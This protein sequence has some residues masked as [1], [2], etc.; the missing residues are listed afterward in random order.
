M[1]FNPEVKIVEFEVADVITVSGD[2]LETQQEET[3]FG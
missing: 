1:M 3:P 2:D